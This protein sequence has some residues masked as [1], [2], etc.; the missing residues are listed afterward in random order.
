MPSYEYL[1]E[2]GT[3]F[4][5][6]EPI[7]KADLPADCPEC[8]TEAPRVLST[9]VAGPARAPR[10]DFSGVPFASAGCCGGACGHRH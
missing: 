7:A 4:D 10:A 6:L 5:R 9:F 8:G 3:R 1:C 2:C